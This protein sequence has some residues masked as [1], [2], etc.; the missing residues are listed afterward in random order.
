MMVGRKPRTK[1]QARALLVFGAP[2][3]GKTTFSQKFANRF[4][5]SHYDL[6]EIREKYHIDRNIILILLTEIAKTGQTLV[7]EGGIGTE[8]ERLEVRN[9]L[10]AASYR[11]FLIWIQTDVASIRARLGARHRSA[12]KAKVIYEESVKNLEAPSESESPIVISGKHTFE[13]QLRHVLRGLA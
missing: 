4:K 5:A 6:D 11:S 1:I 2:C 7:I 8:A 12:R 13:T 10:R 3:S 9:I